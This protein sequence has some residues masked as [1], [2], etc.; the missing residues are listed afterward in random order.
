MNLGIVTTLSG[1]WIRFGL[2]NATAAPTSTWCMGYDSALP[3]SNGAPGNSVKQTW[4][5]TDNE[6]WV[7]WEA[8]CTATA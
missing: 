7:L 5:K 2:T 8:G 3:A 4:A 6:E 1:L